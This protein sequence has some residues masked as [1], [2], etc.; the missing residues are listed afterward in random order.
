[1][2]KIAIICYQFHSKMRLRRWSASEIAE[3]VLQADN[4]LANLID[5]LPPHLQNDELETVETRDRDTH[6]PWIPYQ[7]TSLAMVILYYRL[8]VNR[9]LQSHWLKGSAN[10]A[11]ARSVC[12]SCAMGIVNSAVTCRN[13]SSRMRSWAFAMEIYSSAVTLALE[14]QGSEEQNE[15][16]TLAILECKKFLMGVK[17]Q[18]KLASVALDMLND[19]IQG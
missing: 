6:R 9:I 5:Q 12:L 3:F 13:I 7:K 18:N 4:Q 19:L 16:Y 1:M 11:R 8:A 17:D 10:Y 14:V 2:S 15:H